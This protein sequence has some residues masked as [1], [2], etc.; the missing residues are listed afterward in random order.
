MY[1]A[2]PDNLPRSKVSLIRA[3]E[4]L[5]HEAMRIG[6]IDWDTGHER[7]LEHLRTMLLDPE[8]F[9]HSLIEQIDEKPAPAPRPASSMP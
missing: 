2:R 1:P 4:K 8:I 7:L 9:M 5:R 6:D 3:V